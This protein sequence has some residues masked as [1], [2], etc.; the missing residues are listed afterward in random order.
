MVTFIALVLAVACVAMLLPIFNEVSGKHLTLTPVDSG[1]LIGL[2]L[3]FLVTSIVSGSY[4]AFFLSAFQP[5]QVLKGG[6]TKAGNGSTFFRNVLVTFQFSVSIVLFICTV[7]IYNQL[8][9]IQNKNLGYDKENLLYLPLNGDIKNNLNILEDK[10]KGNSNLNGYSTI[11]EL[12]TDMKSATIGVWW[13]GKEPDTRPMFSIMGIDE[14]FLDVFKMQLVA[15]RGLSK[16][17][18]TDT[19]NYVV[20]EKALQIIGI[21]AASAIGQPLTVFG[22]KGT[23][24]GVVKDFNFK[25]IQQAIEPLI[26][27]L[28]SNPAYLVVRTKPGSTAQAITQLESI[29]QNLNSSY[30]FEYGF[31]DQDLTRLYLTEHR[32]GIL[33]NSF[34]ALAIIIS[35]LGLSGLVAFVSEQRTKEIG[36]RKVLGASVRNVITLLSVGFVK[37]VL[38][39]FMIAA[40]LAW[41]GM[42]KWLEAYAYRITMDWWVFG[43]A[44]ILALL[45]AICTTSFQSVKTALMNPVKSLRSE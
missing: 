4:P 11:S 5:A 29:W 37:L 10:L 1:M 41:Y 44:G 31:V 25:P 45:I 42:Q 16:D 26:L 32:M 8:H 38:V 6:V 22:N 21:N 20:N 27:R 9:F 7:L 43:I 36:I 13:E 12:P 33:F 23:I 40:P 30:S 18:K 24:I 14:S 35:I 17:F 15:G 34:A 2:F 19:T 39:A 28:T 3:I